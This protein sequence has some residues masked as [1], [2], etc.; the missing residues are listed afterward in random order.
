M[1]SIYNEYVKVRNEYGKNSFKLFDFLL[2]TLCNHL[3]SGFITIFS[4]NDNMIILRILNDFVSNLRKADM[5]LD[6]ILIKCIYAYARQFENTR[7][8]KV[9]DNLQPRQILPNDVLGEVFR[10]LCK[11]SN[12]F[13]QS[14]EVSKF[15]RDTIQS[16]L[17][18]RNCTIKQQ[19]KLNDNNRCSYCR[20]VNLL[21]YHDKSCSTCADG[22]EHYCEN[23][24]CYSYGMKVCRVPHYSWN[25]Y[26][27]ECCMPSLR[28]DQ[29]T[30]T[31]EICTRGCYGYNSCTRLTKD[32]KEVAGINACN[33]CVRKFVVSDYIRRFPNA[34]MYS[35]DES[36]DECYD[37]Y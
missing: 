27:P 21:T 2:H 29:P 30:S 10:N 17:R 19:I 4:S 3:E 35:D 26:C 1:Q 11:I 15:A 16:F 37:Y 32:G 5:R 33:D 9:L 34:G 14:M 6:P 18:E 25:R 20:E 8:P 24:G 13:A 23:R 22:C 12:N 36:S 7:I 28:I 31:M